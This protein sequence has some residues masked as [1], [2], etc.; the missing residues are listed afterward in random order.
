MTFPEGPVEYAIFTA[1]LTRRQALSQTG[2]PLSARHL[3]NE[4]EALDRAADL[5]LHKGAAEE[6]NIEI[7]NHLYRDRIVHASATLRPAFLTRPMDGEQAGTLPPVQAD[8]GG[9]GTP[10]MDGGQA[11]VFPDGAKAGASLPMDGWQ[12][13]VHIPDYSWHAGTSSTEEEEEEE[14]GVFSRAATTTVRQAPSSPATDWKQGRSESQDLPLH[15][16][17]SPFDDNPIT[18]QHAGW[19]AGRRGRILRS[20]RLRTRKES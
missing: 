3:L 6:I 4:L 15:S 10:S 1:I 20:A 13:G 14:A 5:L 17:W 18:A 11:G 8:G 16:V 19:P 9:A 7:D 2:N 12:A